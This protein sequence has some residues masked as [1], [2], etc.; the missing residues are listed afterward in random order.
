MS[1]AV[2]IAAVTATLRNLLAHH[3]SP[4]PDLADTIFT[5]Q[6]PDQARQAHATANQ[7]NLFLYHT[8]LNTAWSNTDLQDST[9]RRGESG[10]PPLALNLAYLLTAYGRDNDARRPFSHLLMGHAMRLLHDNPVLG[11]A[12]LRTALPDADPGRM[13]E[14]VRITHH[15]LTLDEITKLW[16]CLQTPHRLSACYQAS[17]VLLDSELPVRAPLPVLRR[18]ARDGGI[19]TQADML[20][21]FPLLGEVQPA[22]PAQLGDRVTLT[23]HNLSGDTV[24]VRIRRDEVAIEF[25]VDP[26][27]SD[28][29]LTFIVPPGPRAR[30]S[31]TTN[32]R[33]GIYAISVVI[34]T[35]GRQRSSNEIAFAIAPRIT[36]PLPLQVA[37]AGHETTIEIECL[38]EVDPD[39]RA[40]LYLGEREVRAEPFR[41]PSTKLRF[42]VTNA[43][44]GEHV[45]RLRVDGIDSRVLADTTSHPLEFDPKARLR[46]IE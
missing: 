21:S 10:L 6:P 7:V 37:K 30:P 26:G 2:A 42:V 4:Q 11:V 46:I 28:Q 22:A 43:P 13:I 15:P 39:Q 1:S 44:L 34:T 5:V 35:D 27:P 40:C 20:S 8:T 18:G 19:V 32:I 3:I 45:L 9:R 17:V 25:L 16:T 14:R 24:A 41:Q 33:A 29:R 12:D 38:P 23:G 31:A 36:S